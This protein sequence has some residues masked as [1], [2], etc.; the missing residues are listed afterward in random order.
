MVLTN[1]NKPLLS[2]SSVD[3]IKGI[4]LKKKE[5]LAR[6]GVNTI[7]DL[8]FFYPRKYRDFSRVYSVREAIYAY[9][10]GKKTSALI[11]GKIIS[12]RKNRSISGKNITR[13]IIGEGVYKVEL[14]FI[15]T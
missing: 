7:R 10:K 14:I 13:V 8:C 4:G 11:G 6:L 2:E 3:N 1:M 12:A 15:G 9:D 5:A